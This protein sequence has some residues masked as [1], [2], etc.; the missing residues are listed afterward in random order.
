M[1]LGRF[2]G[3]AGA[4]RHFLA[5]GAEVTVTDLANREE[6]GEPAELL[7]SSCRLVLGRHVEDD[8]RAADVV[9][10]SPAV[11]TDHPLLHLA[12]RSG[13]RV[14]TEIE[15]FLEACPARLVGITGSNGKT[16]TA[17]LHHALV[18]AAGERAALTGNMGISLLPEVDALAPE[19]IVTV[20]L[21]SFQLER[22]DA[23]PRLDAAVVTR[24]TPNHLDRHGTMERYA[25]AKARI[26]DLLQPGA[27]L[28]VDAR[29]RVAGEWTRRAAD[30][31][32]RCVLV[33]D[34]AVDETPEPL[35]LL[36]RANRRNLAMAARAA[37]TV[38]PR[39]DAAAIT[40]VART[41]RSL[42]HRLETVAVLAG[43]R[44]VD[45][46]KAT[47]PEATAAAI[48]GLTARIH[49]I[50]GGRDKGMDPA[51]LLAAARRC[52]TVT[53]LGE[54]APR[55]ATR[56]PG[57]ARASD[58]DQ[59]VRMACAAARSGDVVLLSPGHASHDM[60]RDYRARGRAFRE[61]VTALGA[62][63]ERG[64]L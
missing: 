37:R 55:L 27:T 47:T 15:L 58:L 23:T 29:C 49:L 40:H 51:P 52:A 20:E 8:F 50:A 45:D 33:D 64:G 31:G 57:A 7:A 4:A 54:T 34:A 28:V 46:S 13:A 6:L 35:H 30:R 62:R 42:P 48:E 22:L 2:G 61:A 24:I 1:G 36:G 5:H 3:G 38:V 19:T 26:V 9:V 39:L 12:R 16:T 14:T 60:F 59:A 63:A 11:P 25:Q 53:L 43:T 17:Y 21:S 41:H 44:F 32:L 56:L 10:A 18:E